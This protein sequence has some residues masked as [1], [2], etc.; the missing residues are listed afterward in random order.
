MVLEKFHRERFDVSFVLRNVCEDY[1]VIYGEAIDFLLLFEGSI[2][3]AERERYQFR[4]L[5]L[6]PLTK[7]SKVA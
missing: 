4:Y 1:P 5:V 3:E 6:E 2:I 7:S